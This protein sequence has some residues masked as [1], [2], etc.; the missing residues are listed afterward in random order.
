MSEYL[1]INQIADL[2]A[3]NFYN[4]PL[5]QYLL[6]EDKHKLC[7]MKKFFKAYVGWLKL[8]SHINSLENNKAVIVVYNPKIKYSKISKIINNLKFRAG[9]LLNFRFYMPSYKYKNIKKMSNMLTSSWV[10]EY[11]NKDEYLHIDL[12]VVDKTIRGKGY[13][14]KLVTPVLKQ[15]HKQNIP[16]TIETHNK[17]NVAI[18]EKYGF[19]LVKVIDSVYHDLK[20]YCL[21][22][23][24]NQIDY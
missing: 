18:Y 13:F 10:R 14:K 22:L 19:K 11:V 16:V 24:P 23:P 6:V 17:N 4:D 21:V 12:V 7:T 8:F 2:M 15:A 5:Y 3:D 20:Q 1:N 9:N